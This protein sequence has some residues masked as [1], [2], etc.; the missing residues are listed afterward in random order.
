MKYRNKNAKTGKKSNKIKTRI[1]N[2]RKWK[3]TK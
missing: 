2:V 3:N 1:F